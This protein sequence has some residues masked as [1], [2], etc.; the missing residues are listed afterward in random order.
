MR[1]GQLRHYMTIQEPSG[2]RTNSGAPDGNWTT[3]ANAWGGFVPRSTRKTD[4]GGL[5]VAETEQELVIRYTAG[6]TAGMRLTYDD[7]GTTRYY[8][9]TGV[10]RLAEVHEQMTLI[11]RELSTVVA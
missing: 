4:I 5:Q 11:V 2:T 1:I 10:S 7:D 9:I 8:D 3:Y 6:V